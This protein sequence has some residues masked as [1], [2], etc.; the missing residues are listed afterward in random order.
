MQRM[1]LTKFR[2]SK[3]KEGRSLEAALDGADLDLAAALSHRLGGAALTVGATSLAII[4]ERITTAARKGNAR[5]AKA[6]RKPLAS[7]I[8]RLAVYLNSEV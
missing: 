7:E 1:V 5:A 8:D 2:S 4:C 6:L 3:I